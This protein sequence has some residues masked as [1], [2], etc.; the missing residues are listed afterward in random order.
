MADFTLKEKTPLAGVSKTFDG[1]EF[2][3]ITGKA[4]VSVATPLGGAK[5]L[6]GA[7]S[8]SYKAAL[9]QT[10]SSTS[11]SD[12]KVHFLGLQSDQMFVLFDRVGDDCV[13]HVAKKL[14]NAGYYSDQSDG[15]VMVAILGQ[16]SRAALARICPL[17][18]HKESF[19]EGAVGRTVMEHLGVIIYRSGPNEFIVLSARS[20]AGSLLHAIETSALNITV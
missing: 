6:S 9:P 18:L 3:E 12:G 16:Q 17:D 19:V 15:W 4:L 8:R 14:G 13:G 1:L 7:M 20:S 11:S 5:D 10:G 2:S